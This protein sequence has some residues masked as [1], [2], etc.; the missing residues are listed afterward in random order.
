MASVN[1]RADDEEC[2]PE[3]SVYR[4]IVTD[5]ADAII[6]IDQDHVIRLCNP[7]AESLFGWPKE[8]MLGQP[9]NLLIPQRFHSAHSE[10][11]DRFR[12]EEHDARYMGNRKGFILGC[13]RG[14]EEIRLGATILHMRSENR[15]LMV[16]IIRDLTERLAHQNE[17]QRLANTDP[18]SGALNRRAFREAAET[19]MHTSRL[20]N[21][22]VALMLFDID[23]F[24]RV[25]D[26]HGHETGD[27]VICEFTD[28][29]RG[30]LRTHDVLGRWGG[31]EF[32]VLLPAAALEQAL[33]IGERIRRTVENT[34]FGNG[35]PGGLQL[36]TSVGVTYDSRNETLDGFIRRADQALYAAKANGRN[37]VFLLTANLEEA[38]AFP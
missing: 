4:R 22:G 18:L 3:A 30:S 10:N 6:G 24:K 25:N 27:Q 11:I 35:L 37:R 29:L 33:N 13:T 32:I 38:A 9:I 20:Y 7:A 19:E 23:H 16:A 26:R 15:P 31:E 8:D 1:A 2:S 12:A 14:G 5:M 21:H 36:T 28:L 34:V 17:L